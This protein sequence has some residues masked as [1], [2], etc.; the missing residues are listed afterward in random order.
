MLNLSKI[1]VDKIADNIALFLK[2]IEDLWYNYIKRIDPHEKKYIDILK[3]ELKRHYQE[4]FDNIKYYPD[5]TN[6][7]TFV[8][9]Y[10]EIHF[11]EI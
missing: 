6:E 5:N 2:G 10:W 4:V 3:K 9:R 11:A 7:W 8:R 1:N